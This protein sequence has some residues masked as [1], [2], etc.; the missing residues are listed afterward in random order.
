MRARQ[1]W[2]IALLISVLLL[3]AVPAAA[4]PPPPRAD[5]PGTGKAVA[6]GGE[7][8][9]AAAAASPIGSAFVIRN[10]PGVAE[11]DPAVAYNLARREFLVV[12]CNDRPDYP[13][14]QAQRLKWDGTPI[15]GPFYIATGSVQRRHPAV[16][17]N[18][19]RDEYLVVWEHCEWTLTS[20]RGRV[21]SGLGQVLGPSD[22]LISDA[23]GLTSCFGPA[24]AYGAMDDRYLVVWEQ[25]SGDNC[26]DIEGQLVR[27]S[28]VEGDNIVI[29]TG[30][31]DYDHGNP[32]VAYN[33]RTNEF[34]VAWERRSD[35][36]DISDICARRVSSTGA[37]LGT[38]LLLMG[39]FHSNTQPAVAALPA[40]SPDGRYLVAWEMQIGPGNR[41]IYGREVAGDG[42]ISSG[43][44]ISGADVDEASP[45]VASYRYAER[46]LVTYQRSADPPY[47][48]TY[49]R[50][51]N[52][53]TD[54]G[55][56]GPEKYIG[57]VQAGHPAVTEGR[58]GDFLVVYDDQPLLGD[59]G[60]YGRLW[61]NR[62]YLPLVLR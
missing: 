36:T 58:L 57:G 10:D 56:P 55:P 1:V 45:A 48:W 17:Y 18:S 53:P 50:G 52:V 30:G 60:I 29:A 19:I 8:S 59:R 20:I 15:G 4:E 41:D 13:D 43:F 14:I 6:P 35:S 34:L 44:W 2:S 49:I 16:A 3:A 38:E 11:V 46:Y 62:I 32:A 25:D 5:P 33:I 9:V 28:L 40:A 26:A 22:I 51:R 39:V 23:P 54:Y 37:L 31:W 61:G 24:V 42:S 27:G 7:A 47:M 12:W 21:V